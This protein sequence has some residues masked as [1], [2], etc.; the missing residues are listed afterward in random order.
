LSDGYFKNRLKEKAEFFEI[1]WL[2]AL[3]LKQVCVII[4]FWIDE[5]TVF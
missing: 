2:L 3:D 4:T 5:K 1:K